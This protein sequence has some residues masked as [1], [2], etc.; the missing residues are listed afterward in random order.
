MNLLDKTSLAGNG[1]II[2]LVALAVNWSG[3][4]LDQAQITETAT[5]IAGTVGFLAAL[6]GQVRRKDL[7]MGLFRK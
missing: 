6:V 4:D 7:E 3:L 1:W 2:L 5:Q